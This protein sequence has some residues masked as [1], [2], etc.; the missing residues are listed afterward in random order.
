MNKIVVVL[1]LL[2]CSV[3]LF[4]CTSVD[5]N[6]SG[7][8]GSSTTTSTAP[9]VPAAI[10]TSADGAAS[11]SLVLQ[12]KELLTTSTA[13][14][15]SLGFIAQ[16]NMV[17]AASG[18]GAGA[19]A[20]YGTYTYDRTYNT[21]G[22]YNIK[23]TFN[24]CRES[25]FQYD[26]TF[27]ANGAPVSF[28]GRLS[29]LT[30]LNFKNNYTTLVG[31]LVGSSLSYKMEGSGDAA[32]ASHLLTANGGISAFDYYSLGR[33]TMSFTA[34]VTTVSVTTN[35]S[36]R[37]TSM[38]T[39][40]KYSVT[41]LGVTTAITYVGFTVITQKQLLTNIED[42]SIGGR[43]SADRTP[44]SGFEGVFDA[45]TPTPIRT[46][47]VPYP[48]TT[49]L[50]TVVT[51]GS[52]TVQYGAVDTIL[53][54]VG[55]DTPQS[56]AKEFM[57]LKQGDF[58]AMEQQLPIVSGTTG[59]ASG[60]VMSISALSTG[61]TPTDLNCYTDV[62]VNYYTNTNPLPADTIKWYVDYDTSLTTCTAQASLPFQ[63]G[64]SSTGVAGDPCDVGLDINASSFDISSGG[65]EHFLAAAL[66]QGYYVLSINNFSC[67][68]TV[69]NIATML[70]G[71]YLFGPYSCTYTDKE[72]DGNGTF[73]GAWCR[74]ADIRV[75][76]SGVI[77]VIAP[78]PLLPPWHL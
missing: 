7:S 54:S 68:T 36:I 22:T 66:P 41:R 47:L 52:A 23:F 48:P 17:S 64:T 35:A 63:Q 29:G 71:D 26:G 28:T 11:A 61:A 24:L 39:N 3:L 2:I 76:A 15:K 8:S 73:P 44:N 31:S 45:A 42:V 43:I 6:D 12:S 65:V 56:F 53:V 67:A 55:T 50:G 5:F 27:S 37:D 77:D 1:V 14:F 13:L 33:H 75:N 30:I 18:T 40:G 19:C 16:S 51:N 21:S 32:N 20:D 34:L 9:L 4:N 59:T 78:D 57:L 60:T 46:V 49:T 25:D 74:L 38:T 10:T 58:Y 69:S 62:H 72:A 70:I